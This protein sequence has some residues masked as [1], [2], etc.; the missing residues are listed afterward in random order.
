MAQDAEKL[1]AQASRLRELKGMA[2]GLTF[3]QIGDAVG[4]TERQAQRWFSGESD[5]G[6]ENLRKL[7]GFLGSSPDYIEYGVV[8]KL[9][10]D[11][12]PDLMGDPSHPQAA[13]LVKIETK[14]DEILEK[15]TQLEIARAGDQSTPPG[16]RSR[17]PARRKP[18]A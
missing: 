9:R 5:P 17:K 4:V 2:R 3:R 13:Q 16:T 10:P 7:A 11:R 8:K 6:A 12:A 1:A 14:L 18:E 15:L